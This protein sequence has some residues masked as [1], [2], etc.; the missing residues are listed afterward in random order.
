[1][2]I[3]RLLLSLVVYIF[4]LPLLI[5]SVPSVAI[6]LL[7]AW[8]GRSFFFGNAK[9]GRGDQNPAWMKSGYWPAFVWLL[10]RNPLNNFLIF[11]LSLKQKP[12]TIKGDPGIGEKTN[13]GFYAIRMGW[14][15]EYY[16]IIKY[17]AEPWLLK[18]LPST[19]K[20]RCIRAR[21]GWKINGNDSPTAPFVCAINPWKPYSGK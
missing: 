8:D 9:W 4:S 18:L 21:F 3:I 15:W 13:A 10:W 2:I 20:N 19:E 14:A 1:M 12:Y 17:T 5:I 11:D 6:L 16:W 7:T